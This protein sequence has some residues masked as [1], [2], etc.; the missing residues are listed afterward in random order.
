MNSSPTNHKNKELLTHEFIINNTERVQQSKEP[1]EYL[2]NFIL[3]ILK[4][5]VAENTFKKVILP[6]RRFD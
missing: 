3:L 6:I 2:N 5:H 1:F 4:I